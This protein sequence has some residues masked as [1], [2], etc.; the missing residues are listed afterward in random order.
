MKL[1]NTLNMMISENFIN[2]MPHTVIMWR[3]IAV[4]IHVD[5]LETYK[6]RMDEIIYEVSEEM[7]VLP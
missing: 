7:S 2:P 5:I 4:P 6:K 3:Q 1:I